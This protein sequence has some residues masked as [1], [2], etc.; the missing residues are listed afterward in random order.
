MNT[1]ASQDYDKAPETL[2]FRLYAVDS[3]YSIHSCLYV[4]NIKRCPKFFLKSID[5]K[6]VLHKIFTFELFATKSKCGQ[7]KF[8]LDPL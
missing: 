7:Q 2:L 8:I 3:Q 1:V 6:S 5:L 4:S